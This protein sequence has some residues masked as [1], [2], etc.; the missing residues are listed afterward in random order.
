MR[1]NLWANARAQERN[2][3]LW[4]RMTAVE[5]KIIN[6][7]ERKSTYKISKAVQKS[8]YQNGHL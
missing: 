5:M 6:G 1:R 7:S 2:V 3:V 4:I 8:P